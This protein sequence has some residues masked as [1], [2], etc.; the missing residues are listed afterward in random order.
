MVTVTCPDAFARRALKLDQLPV[1]RRGK[2]MPWSS[3]RATQL[4]DAGFR[5]RRSKMM[6]IINSKVVVNEEDLNRDPISGTPGAH[7]LGTGAGAA[8]GGA[9][10]AA[11]GMAVGGPVGSVVGAAIGAV[12]GGLA[13]KGVAEAVNPTAEESYWRDGYERQ[14]F[15]AKD[16]PYEYY[17]PGFRSGW[18]GWVR[19]DGRKF[20]EVEPDLA[21]DYTR[22]KTEIQPD[23]QTVKPAARAAWDRVDSNLKMKQ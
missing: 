22:S 13:G 21:S 12:A 14:L 9:A 11:V 17:A 2:R 5:Q 1:E 15:Y 19:H 3:H 10:G 7:P 4:S 18:E 8:S 16:K 6:E 20:E 23:W